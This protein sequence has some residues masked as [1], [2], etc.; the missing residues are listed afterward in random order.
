VE[1][2]SVGSYDESAEEL[3]ERAPVGYFSILANG[4]IPRVN[5]TLLDWT[6]YSRE[7]FLGS[8][9]TSLLTVPGRIYYETS[10][11]P[12]LQMRGTVREVAFDLLCP[13]RDTLPVLINFAQATPIPGRQAVTRASVFD[14]TER[15][16][17]ERELLAARRTAEQAVQIEQVAREAAERASRVKDDFLAM[18][19][20]ELRTPLAAILGW[21]TLLR[22]IQRNDP[23]LEQGLDVIERN[24][25]VQ[26]QLVDDLLD[27]GRVVSG[28]LRLNVQRV[29]LV[30]TID[31]ALETSRFAAEVKSIRVQSVLDPSIL[32]SGDPGR[33]QQIFWNLLS[34]AVK[35]TPKGGTIAIVMKRVNSHVEIS[36]IDS[37]QG[38]TQEFLCKAFDRFRQADSSVTR[39]SSGLGL[40]LSIVKQLVE[41]HGGSIEAYSAGTGLGSTFT[42][43]LPISIVSGDLSISNVYPREAIT[44]GP[45][46]PIA[47]SLK[48][49]TVVVVEDQKDSRELL[50]RVLSEAGAEVVAVATAAEALA[51]IS[52]YKPQVFISDIGL[53]DLD[54][55]ELIRR[56]RMNSEGSSLPAI[57][58]TA[59]A[60]IEDRTQAMMAGFQAHLA[61]PVDARELLLAVASLAGRLG[62]PS[63]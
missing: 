13:G 3:F 46:V 9:F 19:S 24:A 10:V 17:Y 27:I 39:A 7:V 37:G 33:L 51:A 52:T 56:V 21:T 6:G 22:R 1:D 36:V 50:E 58:L 49:V 41:M 57:A 29:E 4:S 55:Y 8:R 54:G 44:L 45:A 38:M 5:Q 34:N 16:K 14:A 28:K 43:H 62:T 11:A 15:R 23:K 18:I 35:F 40:G 48:G 26:T 42:V 25:K 2:A 47:T 60:R 61:K 31:A 30:T 20:H 53:P 59:F 32:V 63:G 12:A